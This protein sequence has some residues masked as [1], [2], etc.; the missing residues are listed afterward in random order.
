MII[1]YKLKY[2]IFLIRMV[3]YLYICE[4]NIAFFLSFISL[5]I[6]I[7]IRVKLNYNYTKPEK[8]VIGIIISDLIFGISSFCNDCISK[9]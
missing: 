4:E 8:I 1:F 3:S 2:N 9:E 5:A 7:S 6:V